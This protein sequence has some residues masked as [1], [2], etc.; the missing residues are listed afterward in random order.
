MRKLVFPVVIEIRYES[1]ITGVSF[2]RKWLC[3]DGVHFHAKGYAVS[4]QGMINEEAKVSS[5]D[6]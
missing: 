3:S 6:S 2:R 1:T 5:T 4:R